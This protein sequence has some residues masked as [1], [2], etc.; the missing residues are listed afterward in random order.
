MSAKTARGT[1]RKCQNEECGASFYDLGREFFECPVCGTEFDH[2]AAARALEP[3]PSRYPARK[4]PRDLPIVAN[5]EPDDIDD[6][7]ADIALDDDDTTDDADT[8]SSDVL[9]VDDDDDDIDGPIEIPISK[10]DDEL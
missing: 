5:P 1:K 4:Q 2:E 10:H 3:Q 9:L 8:D 6:D 7:A